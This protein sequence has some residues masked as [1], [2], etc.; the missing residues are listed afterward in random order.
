MRSCMKYIF[1][2][3][4]R[5]HFLKTSFLEGDLE[6]QGTSIPVTLTKLSSL[7][8]NASV[9]SPL[10]R[11]HLPPLLS[12]SAFSPSYVLFHCLVF[13]LAQSHRF[14]A[15]I[16]HHTP[17]VIVVLRC[18]LG[19]LRS[20]CF[21]S[22][23]ACAWMFFSC[24]SVC[25]YVSTAT[26]LYS[27]ISLWFVPASENRFLKQLKDAVEWCLCVCARVCVCLQD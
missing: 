16:P 12:D 20:A 9:F 23:D 10:L 13:A 21:C 18:Y 4:I 27:Q 22:N 1:L 11:L 15:L 17:Q 6:V 14:S 26:E 3:R 7:C 5:P 25:V 2:D 24:G 19:A 8:P